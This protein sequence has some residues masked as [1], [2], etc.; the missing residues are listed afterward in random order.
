MITTKRIDFVRDWLGHASSA[1]TEKY[2]R[3]DNRERLAFAAAM[4]ERL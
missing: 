3:S 4:G 2:L 1:T